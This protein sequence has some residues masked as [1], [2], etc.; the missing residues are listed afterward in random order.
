M[1]YF[2]FI[3]GFNFISLGFW[4]WQCMTMSLKR[5][6]IKFKPRITLNHNSYLKENMK[7]TFEL[8]DKRF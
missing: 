8:R 7:F 4:V 1:M 2:N 5:G 3:L 6:K